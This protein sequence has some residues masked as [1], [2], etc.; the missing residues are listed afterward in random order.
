MRHVKHPK[1]LYPLFFTELWERFGFYSLQTIIIL[2]MSKA[3]LFSDH[4]AYMLY[5]TFGSMIYLT[6]V[7]G[8]YIADKWLGYQKTIIL[9]GIF[10]TCG[11]LLT[12]LLDASAFT[13]GLSI[14]IIGN[15]LFKPSVSSIVGE[16]Y[17]SHDHR[18]D[19]GFTLFYMGINIGSM[20]PPLVAGTVVSYFGWHAGFLMAALGM[21]IG[22]STFLAF[23]K[24]LKGAG[25]LPFHNSQLSPFQFYFVFALCIAAAI[26]F[27]RLLFTYPYETNIFL[28]IA[29]ALVVA[30]LIAK[31]IKLQKE[32]KNKLIACFIL[33]L[34]SIG[35]W[36][37]YNQT[38]TSLMLFADRNM[39]KELLHFPIDAEF[40][41]FFNPFFIVLLSPFLS[42][43][44][45]KL[46]KSHHNPSIPT[47]FAFGILLIAI[48][49]FFLNLGIRFFSK[50][51]FASPWWLIGSYFLQTVGE[52]LLSPIGLSMITTLSPKPLVGT[53]MGIWFLS[54]SAAF[55]IG[56]ALASFAAVPSDTTPL[57]SLAIYDHAF[58]LY[59]VISLIAA[60]ISFM[61]IPYLKKLIHGSPAMNPIK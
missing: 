43:L 27:F 28:S 10:L 52:L 32:E 11:Y 13:L 58:F 22:L 48:G 33:I 53:M 39:T 57:K 54:T 3:L 31:I 29:A 14:L 9:G 26:A 56:A 24:I 49:F 12:A 16:L 6:P 18:R 23:K 21:V 59:G 5:G 7:L 2:Y 25:K 50:G 47:K 61:L 36:A 45:T 41:Q 46:T 51:G 19:A 34:T 1:G 8:G 17:L 4:K 60:F 38:Y 20:L 35:F 30:Y 15:G 37:V 40:M 44:W 55:A 42:R